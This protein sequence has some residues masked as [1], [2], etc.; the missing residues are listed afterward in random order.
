MLVNIGVLQGYSQTVTET[1]VEAAVAAL[2]RDRDFGDSLY[3]YDVH[4]KVSGV[5]GVDY[6]NVVITGVLTTGGGIDTTGID[7]YGNLI[8]TS[9]QVITK[10]TVTISSTVVTALPTI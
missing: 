9:R 6:A 2:L 8:I 10:G 7:Q 4:T 1:A 3:K 5:D